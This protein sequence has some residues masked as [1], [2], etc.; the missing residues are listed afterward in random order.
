MSLPT[1]AVVE[2]LMGLLGATTVAEIAGVKETRAVQQWASGEREPQHSHVLR[3][4]LQL[5]MMISTVTSRHMAAAWFRG[6]NPHLDDQVPIVL[7]RDQPLESIQI[8]LMAAVRSFAARN[9]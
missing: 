1:T 8:P 4:A 7:L 3:F 2:T 6:A 9:V 5:A